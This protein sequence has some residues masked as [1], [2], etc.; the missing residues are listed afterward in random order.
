MT[1]A[2]SIGR[3][4]DAPNASQGFNRSCAH[5]KL[6]GREPMTFQ[7]FLARHGKNWPQDGEAVEMDEQAERIAALEAE[8]ESL[9]TP[10]A[11]EAASGWVKGRKFSYTAKNGNVTKHTVVSVAGGKVIT[12]LKRKNGEPYSF[13]VTALDGYAASQIS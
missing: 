12:N 2:T 7:A 10:V 6:A 8:L 5:A 4:A 1:S 13:A 3:I 11:P 9:R